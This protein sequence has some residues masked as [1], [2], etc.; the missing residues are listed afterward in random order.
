MNQGASS[1]Q[2]NQDF[3]V[4]GEWRINWIMNKFFILHCHGLNTPDESWNVCVKDETD[5]KGVLFHCRIPACNVKAPGGIVAAAIT[6]RFGEAL[7]S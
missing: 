2:P 7:Q 5:K 4:I 6:K 3:K 1:Q